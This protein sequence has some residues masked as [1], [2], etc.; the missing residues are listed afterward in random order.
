MTK[1]PTFP[2]VRKGCL[3]L[4]L[5]FLLNNFASTQYNCPMR[6]IFGVSINKFFAV[7]LA[8][9]ALILLALEFLLSAIQFP[10]STFIFSNVWN[11]L[12]LVVCYLFLLITNIRND[13][14]AYVSIL[15]LV[16]FF[17]FD[18]F[19]GI[20]DAAQFALS[21]M[22]NGQVGL[23][24]LFTLSIVLWAGQLAMGVLAYIFVA[25]YRFG[26]SNNFNLVRLFAL[27]FLLSLLLTSIASFF[28]SLL[29]GATYTAME[30]VLLFF[31]DIS[32]FLA[33]SSCVFTLNRLRRL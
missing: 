29:S 20:I 13:D 12:L 17:A 8:S 30:L 1:A 33:V 10:A 18:A 15:L 2:S 6:R 19:F 32:Q 28:L 23:G 25:R 24:L 22:M 4:W 7:S 26:R 14:R 31:Y 11:H 5:F 9:A 21:G 27:L 16:F 3:A